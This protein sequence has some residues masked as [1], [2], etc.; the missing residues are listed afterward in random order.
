MGLSKDRRIITC[1]EMAQM[2]AKAMANQDRGHRAKVAELDSL[3]QESGGE[4][5][6]DERFYTIPLEEYRKLIEEIKSLKRSQYRKCYD[7]LNQYQ[8]EV[9]ENLKPHLK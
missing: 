9:Q 7:L 1:F 4:L 2:I 3:W 8:L 6:Q 5:S